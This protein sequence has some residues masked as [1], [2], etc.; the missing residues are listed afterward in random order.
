MSAKTKTTR[1]RLN[2]SSTRR[3]ARGTTP[4]RWN[5]LAG[6]TREVVHIFER[7]GARGGPYW[8]LV[9]ECGHSVARKRHD[10]RSFSAIAQAMFRPL[11]ERLA[12]RHAQCHYCGSGCERQDP[13]VLIKLFEGDKGR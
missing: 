12:P 2:T 4:R 10:P 7:E 5:D 11:S 1:P 6:P 9:L 13:M 3:H 8:R